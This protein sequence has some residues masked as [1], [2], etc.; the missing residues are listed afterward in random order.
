MFGRTVRVTVYSAVVSPSAAVTATR[1]SLSPT[2]KSVPPVT[3]KVAFRSVVSTNTD[4]SV[5]KG[6]RLTCAPSSTG[7]PSTVNV[8]RVTL[9]LSKTN[10]VNTYSAMVSSSTAVTMTVKVFS[11]ITRPSFPEISIVAS[12]SDASTSTSTVSVPASSSISSPSTTVT[13]LIEMLFTLASLFGATFK[14]I[15][16]STAVPSA[17]VTVTTRVFSRV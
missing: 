12:G 11:P 4:T 10:S 5:V 16:Y 8:D 1:S 13:P 14:V 2:T 3:S 6:A 17:A 15:V 9:V 7:S